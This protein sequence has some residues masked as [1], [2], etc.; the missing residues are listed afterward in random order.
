M[1]IIYV[2]II[3]RENLIKLGKSK[4]SISL[5]ENV[6]SIYTSSSIPLSSTHTAH[7]LT[8]LFWVTFNSYDIKS[9]YQ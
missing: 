2:F 5:M 1:L 8:S 4:T 6:S 9:I 3:F 7:I